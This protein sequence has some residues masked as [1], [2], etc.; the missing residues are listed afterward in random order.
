MIMPI[1]SVERRGEL[2]CIFFNSEKNLIFFRVEQCKRGQMQQQQAPAALAAPFSYDNKTIV[3]IVGKF[4]YVHE[5]YNMVDL[6]CTLSYKINV[7]DLAAKLTKKRK[8]DSSGAGHGPGL[9]TNIIDKYSRK[10]PNADGDDDDDDEKDG[11]KDDEEEGKEADNGDDD[12]DDDDDDEDSQAGRDAKDFEDGLTRSGKPRKQSVKF[13]LKTFF[14]Y[15]PAILPLAAYHFTLVPGTT[16][17]PPTTEMLVCVRIV[18]PTATITVRQMA[19]KCMKLCPYLKRDKG[20]VAEIARISSEV[21]RTTVGNVPV[22]TEKDF[23]SLRSQTLRIKTLQ[24]F[25]DTLKDPA[26][27]ALFGL[28]PD[29]RLNEMSEQER[30]QL[31]Q[32]LHN[33]NILPLLFSTKNQP[34]SLRRLFHTS[35]FRMPALH[36]WLKQSGVA[37]EGRHA[38]PPPVPDNIGLLLPGEAMTASDLW[39]FWYDNMTANGRYDWDMAFVSKELQQVTTEEER[40]AAW[41]YLI[42]NEHVLRIS[43]SVVSPRIPLKMMSII[44]RALTVKP[45]VHATLYEG[46]FISSLKTIAATLGDN[47]PESIAERLVFTP[48]VVNSRA[49]NAASGW[50]TVNFSGIDEC[51]AEVVA[52][53]NTTARLIAVDNMHQ[54]SLESAL[55]L[56]K[57][58]FESERVRVKKE[59]TYLFITGQRIGTA[60]V[61][62]YETANEKRHL[63]L[64]WQHFL[65]S[66]KL[67]VPIV[68]SMFIPSDTELQDS[69]KK[70]VTFSDGIGKTLE[71]F[72][73]PLYDP[74]ETRMQN[75][76]AP[77]TAAEVKQII[78][79]IKA[80]R[81][82]WTLSS[83]TTKNNNNNNN[84]S[85]SAAA[86]APAPASKVDKMP[87]ILFDS[88]RVLNQIARYERATKS[89]LFPRSENISVFESQMTELRQDMMVI[90]QDGGQAEIDQ[91][92]TETA[93]GSLGSVSH[94]DLGFTPHALVFY[95]LYGDPPTTRRQWSKEPLQGFTPM[96]VSMQRFGKADVVILV[97]TNTRFITASALT[98]AMDLANKKVLM[99]MPKTM[100]K[101]APYIL[102]LQP[103]P[104]LVDFVLEHGPIK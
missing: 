15:L 38:P 22:Q 71:I 41:Q 33:C 39:V 89:E 17:F 88:S 9:F 83:T 104:N 21:G 24:L 23:M 73:M 29:A 95:R 8:R 56:F 51:R 28:F 12:N 1:S 2:L 65:G 78:D 98:A 79:K 100:E 96:P 10:P 30:I 48:T 20:A 81:R 50:P 92:F 91:I 102:T 13:K 74:D 16:V 49:C 53:L 36:R 32:D 85:S 76:L 58:I 86:A 66:T 47:F 80:V 3:S 64:C 55:E 27:Y 69:F 59:T 54:F 26:Y 52:R 34:M 94:I 68:T 42:K 75:K 19:M 87:L 90:Q 72:G 6:N 99:L 60:V 82:T 57:M 63:P 14:K 4:G 70:V 97:V 77:L 35:T 61:C 40:M 31:L 37:Y 5:N 18:P 46:D 93:F 67:T 62:G 43:E 84:A 44:A 25:K 7:D 101:H 11:D 103:N 45:H